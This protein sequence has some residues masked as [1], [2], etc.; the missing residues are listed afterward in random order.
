MNQTEFNEMWV[1]IAKENPELVFEMESN[2]VKETCDVTI[3]TKE[4][5]KLAWVNFSYGLFALEKPVENLSMFVANYEYEY[6][7]YDTRATTE[8]IEK[9][10]KIKN[11]IKGDKNEEV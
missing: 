6:T 2:P 5:Y 9:I 7:G 10:N 8:E 4:G 1:K 11:T 3:S